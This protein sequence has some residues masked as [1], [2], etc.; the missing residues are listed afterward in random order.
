MISLVQYPKGLNKW[1]LDSK[2]HQIMHSLTVHPLEEVHPSAE[3]RI[4]V[5]QQT[6]EV[7]GMVEVD[8]GNSVV[9][10]NEKKSEKGNNGNHRHTHDVKQI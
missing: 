3:E 5:V 1:F 7:A 6:V 8:L 4:E 10:L 2:Q 9:G